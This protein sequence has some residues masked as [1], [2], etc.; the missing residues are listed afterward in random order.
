[1]V[2]EQEKL[3]V[4]LL[5]KVVNDHPGTPWARRAQKE[6]DDGF[7]FVLLIDFGIRRGF[8]TRSSC[9]ISDRADMMCWSCEYDFAVC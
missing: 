1:M 4:D 7:G 9:P 6:I 3:S 8:A 2:A 5:Q